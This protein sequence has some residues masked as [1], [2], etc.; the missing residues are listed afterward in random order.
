MPSLHA[1][2]VAITRPRRVGPVRRESPHYQ[3]CQHENRDHYQERRNL[4][5]DQTLVHQIEDTVHLQPSNWYSF[6]PG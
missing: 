5:E 2:L 6:L 1:Y 3:R 4:S